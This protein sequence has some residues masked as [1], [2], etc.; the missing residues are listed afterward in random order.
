MRHSYVTENDIWN[1][2]WRLAILKKQL[3]ADYEQLL[4]VFFR[5]FRGKK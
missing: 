4:R 2:F 1:G 3:V 5:V